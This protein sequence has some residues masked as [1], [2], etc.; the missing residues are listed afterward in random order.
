MAQQFVVIGGGIIGLA[1]AYKLLL[2]Q[3]GGPK[4]TLLEKEA[5]PARHQSG[6]NSGV[7]H[8][9]LYYKPGSLKAR[10]CTTGRQELTE[11]CQS[12]TRFL[13]KYAESWW[14]RP[15]RMKSNR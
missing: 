10:L 5:G 1:T 6:R 7:I 8:A 14:L 4:V 12:V 2:A 9:G 13:T 3:P 11:F 15:R